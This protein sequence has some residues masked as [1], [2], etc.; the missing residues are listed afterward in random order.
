M[1]KT[2]SLILLLI[3]GLTFATNQPASSSEINTDEMQWARLY[4]HYA[5]QVTT[6]PFFRFPQNDENIISRLETGLRINSPHTRVH[7][8]FRNFLESLPIARY[9]DKTA[10]LLS[11]SKKLGLFNDEETQ[12]LLRIILVRDVS[13][14]MVQ[15]VTEALVHIKIEPNFT[16]DTPV[17]PDDV[18]IR[19][20]SHAVDYFSCKSSY[21]KN[22]LT[23]GIKNNGR[24]LGIL[25]LHACYADPQSVVYL[26]AQNLLECVKNYY[27]K[28][29]I[30]LQQNLADYPGRQELDGRSLQD[31]VELLIQLQE[32][33]AA[34]PQQRAA[35]SAQ[36]Q[37]A[38]GEHNIIP[39]LSRIVADYAL[40]QIP[41]EEAAAILAIPIPLNNQ[42][43]VQLPGQQLAAIAAH[44]P[45]Q[46]P[47]AIRQLQAPPG[48]MAISP[49]T[50][51]QDDEEKKKK[52]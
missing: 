34:Q 22:I 13:D 1:F 38:L 42:N 43:I 35:A 44:A 47:A 52:E 12:K 2:L 14:E 11:A 15:L 24:K 40:P 51:R 27:P 23:Q 4:E 29:I 21:F 30:K 37:D 5:T 9:L 25:F 3:P 33:V 45:I 39:D 7:P 49:I 19:S 10:L 18:M 17:L 50:R 41:A 46:V 16:W 8:T 26:M 6:P 36:I 20:T 32:F 48:P 28:R 31:V